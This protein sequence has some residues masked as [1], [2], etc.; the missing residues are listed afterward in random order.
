LVWFGLVWFGLVLSLILRALWPSAACGW[1]STAA[2]PLRVPAADCELFTAGTW[3]MCGDRP[4]RGGSQLC[5][6][7]PC[8]LSDAAVCCSFE[9]MRLRAR[10]LGCYPS[11]RRASLALCLAK[12]RLLSLLALWPWLMSLK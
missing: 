4:L 5:F 1:T 12:L 2:F 8:L 11:K 3:C 7:T 6:L 9:C 10:T